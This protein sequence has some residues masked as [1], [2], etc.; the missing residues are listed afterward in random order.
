M[1]WIIIASDKFKKESEELANFFTK[2]NY[3][4]SLYYISDSSIDSPERFYVDLHRVSHCV[5]ISDGTVPVNPHLFYA[6]GYL[7]GASLPVFVT[8]LDRNDDE[9]KI[10]PNFHFYNNSEELIKDIESNFPKYIAEEE[11]KKAHKKLF[12][13]G[14]PFTPDCFSTYIAKEDE[15]ICNLFYEAGM[16]VNV[17]DAAGTP[18][19]C[20]AARS[21]RKDMIEW[22]V[23]RGAEIDA[24]SQDRGYSAVMD[25]VWKSS[26]DIVDKLIKL[27][28][29]LNFVSNDGQTALIVATGA[30]NPRICELLVKNG[31]DPNFK[32]RMGM[33]SLDY[34]RL[35]KKTILIPLYEE[36][37]K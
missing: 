16:S 1:N 8:G 21:G 6:T 33:S 32:D 12:E 4:P 31:A 26:L 13:M 17:R 23:D 29:N 7:N 20:I 15:E 27:G 9:K 22:L 11:Q 24:I 25:A 19:L 36:Y 5:F 37:S 34:A 30:S 28:A 3:V 18:M 14:I 2:K 10:L 35:F